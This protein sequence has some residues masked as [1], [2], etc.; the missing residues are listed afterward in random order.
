MDELIKFPTSVLAKQKGFNLFSDNPLGYADYQQVYDPDGTLCWLSLDADPNRDKIWFLLSKCNSS[1]RNDPKN[2]RKFSIKNRFEPEGI[3]TYLVPTQTTLQTWL[4]KVHK[5]NIFCTLNYDDNWI[6]Q[7]CEFS[8]G[9]KTT[10]SF[11]SFSTY[12]EAL[13]AGLL[14]VLTLI[15]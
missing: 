5:Y 10:M 1:D 15:P 2:F 12:E 4:R 3:D 9:N 8:H 7:I 11:D 13:E 14:K 6:Y